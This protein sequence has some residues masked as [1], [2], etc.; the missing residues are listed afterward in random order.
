VLSSTPSFRGDPNKHT[1]SKVDNALDNMFNAA[2]T[3]ARLTEKQITPEWE[4]LDHT[5]T[6]SLS[7]SLS[8]S[9]HLS[10]STW[11]EL[12]AV[13]DDLH[14]HYKSHHST[15]QDCKSLWGRFKQ[16]NVP[17]LHGEYQERTPIQNTR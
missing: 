13:L 11:Q 9:L 2:M 5:S 12:L 3:V 8:L 17:A 15:C 1:A 6:L 7:L 14:E 4:V 10:L 16:V